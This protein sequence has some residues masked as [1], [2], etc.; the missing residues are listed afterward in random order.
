MFYSH[1]FKVLSIIFPKLITS[2]I[3]A[4]KAVISALSIEKIKALFSFSI[5]IHTKFIEHG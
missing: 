2:L 3:D 1:N 5:E 4:L